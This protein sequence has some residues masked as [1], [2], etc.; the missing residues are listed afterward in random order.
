MQVEICRDEL[1]IITAHYKKQIIQAYDTI[2]K[3]NAYVRVHDAEWIAGEIAMGFTDPAQDIA[4]A[5]KII[6]YATDR[7]NH[8]SP[9]IAACR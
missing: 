8:Y 2:A 6:A 1:A 5:R 7:I 3:R 9:I 4:E